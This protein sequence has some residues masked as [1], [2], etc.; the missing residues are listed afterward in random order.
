MTHIKVPLIIATLLFV[1]VCDVFADVDLN[2]TFPSALAITN[3]CN[4]DLVVLTGQDHF[5]IHST[6]A[7]SGNFEFYSDISSNYSGAG[8]LSG[9]SYQGSRDVFFDFSS[10]APFPF[11][12]TFAND[13]LLQSATGVDNF[14]LRL[15]MHIT[16][17]ADGV[18][19]ASVDDFTTTCNG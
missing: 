8:A 10:Q 18:P 15:H 4:G 12:F 3:P 11:V 19:T 14:K 6:E 9:V 1:G 16:I 2:Q 13:L 7:T 5:L 17:N